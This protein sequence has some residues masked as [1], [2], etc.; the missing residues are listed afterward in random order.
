MAEVILPQYAVRAPEPNPHF[1]FPLQPPTEEERDLPCGQS[2]PSNTRHR[3]QHL[4]F[5]GLPPPLP[6]FDFHS[7]PPTSANSFSESPSRSPG[8]P[9]QKG[10]RRNGSE[11][12]G[13][14]MRNGGVGV[15][16][17]S[18]TKS[19]QNALP[20]PYEVK[21]QVAD[22]DM[23]TNGLGQSQ[24]TTYPPFSLRRKNQGPTVYPPR[25]RNSRKKSALHHLYLPDQ[26]PIRTQ[27]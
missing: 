27:R 16:S 13:G 22:E 26:L 1:V 17:S 21:P 25:L 20:P 5:T 24:A 6:Q 18:P 7:T 12:I 15:L 23:P 14:D 11:F 10:H 2:K 9:I 3:P 8:R 19:Q 4:S